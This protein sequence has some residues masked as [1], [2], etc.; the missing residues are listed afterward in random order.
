MASI[1]LSPARGLG[2]LESEPD[3]ADSVP[4]SLNLAYMEEDER[5][6]ETMPSLLKSSEL[7]DSTTV[8]RKNKGQKSK[9]KTHHSV[10]LDYGLDRD[11]HFSMSP[12]NSHLSNRQ[13]DLNA[14]DDKRFSNAMNKSTK[15]KKGKAVKDL[16]RRG[17]LD[18][19]DSNGGLPWTFDLDQ[20]QKTKD[21]KCNLC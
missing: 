10:A 3:E 14:S 21:S 5:N 17:N 20:V 7:R 9:H 18:L 11:P 15:N 19:P 1:N 13:N 4:Q 12:T 6:E 2:F 8:I 16:P